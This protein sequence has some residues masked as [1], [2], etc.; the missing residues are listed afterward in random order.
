MADDQETAAK[1]AGD[2][3]ER[4]LLKATQSVA[5]ELVRIVKTGEDD[6]DRL[7]CKIAKTLAQLAL[8]GRLGGLGGGAVR[9]PPAD[10]G[11][12]SWFNQ[13]AKALA[14]VAHRGMRFTSA[15]FMR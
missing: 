8:N 13:T 1:A 10:E 3:L 9:D 11:S 5:R 6:L 15:H 12:L 2:A 14:K 7:G 4:A